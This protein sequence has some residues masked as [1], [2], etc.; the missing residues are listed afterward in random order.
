MPTFPSASSSCPSTILVDP[1]RLAVLAS[2][3]V[4]DT[5]AEQGFDDIVALASHMC[6]T[7]V[8]LVSLVAADRQWFKARTGFSLNE[9]PLD[10]SVCAHALGSTDVLVIPDMRKDP[11]TSHNP[12]VTGTPPLRFYAGAPLATPEGVTLGTICVMDHVAR[13]DGLTPVQIEALAALARQAVSLMALRRAVATRD[14]ALAVQKA[15]ILPQETLIATQ[16]RVSNAGGDFAAILDIV[17]QGLLEAMPSVEGCVFQ[18]IEGDHLV[19]RYAVGTCAAHVG[20]RISIGASLSGACLMGEKA[21][22]CGDV[23]AD[24]RSDMAAAASLGLRSCIV[25]PVARDGLVIGVLFLQAASVDV[26]NDRDLQ[27]AQLFAGTISAGLAAAGEADARRAVRSSEERYRAVFESAIDYAIV[28]MDLR[29]IVTDW[30]EGARRVFGWTGEEMLGRSVEEF[31]TMDDVEAGVARQEMDRALEAGRGADERWHIRKGGMPFWANGEM[32]VLRD[33]DGAAV[34][35]VKMLRDRTEQRNAM[36]ALQASESNLRT[37]LATVPVGI[38]FADAPSGRIVGRNAAMDAITRAPPSKEPKTLATYGEWAAFHADGTRV[39]AH[40]FP[41]SRILKEDL[42][43]AKLQVEYQRR[44]GSRVWIDIVGRPIRDDEGRRTGAVIAVSDIDARIK[45]EAMQS[46]MNHELSHRMKNL[47]AMVQAIAMQSMRG[48]SD[49]ATVRDVLSN[50]LVV[51]GKAHDLLLGGF[52]GRTMIEPVIRSGIGVHDDDRSGRFHYRGDPVEIGAKAALAL[53]MMIHELS[54]NAA[55]Y[56]ALTQPSGF[57]EVEWMVD[58]APDA[59]HFTI[60]WREVGGPVVAP[61]T[62]RGFGSRLIERSLSGLKGGTVALDFAPSGV[63]CRVA[64]PLSSFQDE[65]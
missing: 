19:H 44:D 51:L 1:K 62:R 56:G 5:P 60:I 61:P 13:P 15:S 26:F 30:N 46:L 31:F 12:L 22:L 25:V 53:A 38:M 20:L 6:S 48:V 28:V 45:A 17:V 50:R 36:A 23:L 65:L 4:L 34:G 43:E 47:L 32:M 16:R 57:V 40:E 10:Q 41:L 8:A 33:E 2:Y 39:K 7:P 42:E 37:I 21:I 18:E 58:R 55:K 27:L 11:R 9:T 59:E 64:A 49:V 52:V 24:T 63:V 54:T 35:F 14:E 29:G 3:A